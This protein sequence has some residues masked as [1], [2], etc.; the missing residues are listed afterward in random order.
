MG[1]PVTTSA[2]DFTIIGGGIIGCAIARALAIGG[3]GR[4]VVVERNQ[5]GGEASGAA[6]GVLAVASS[7]A[8][9]GVVFELKRASAA[10]FSP[11]AEALRAETGID[12]EY[13]TAGLLDLSFSSR[14]AEH[15]DLLA[16]R[17][18]EQGFTDELLDVWINY[19]TKNEADPVRM[20]P[21]PYEFH[22]YYD[23]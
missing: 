1:W 23:I 12:V 17:R 9:R 19:K 7:R 10:L 15:L 20:R 14:E 16:V 6:A 13:S 21:H 18:R 5:P 8:P 22:I 2:P 4:I 11:L 3:A